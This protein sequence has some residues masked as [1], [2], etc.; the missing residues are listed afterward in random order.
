[1]DPAS[2]ASLLSRAISL[3]TGCYT[4]CSFLKK[5]ISDAKKVDDHLRLCQ[6]EGEYLCVVLDQLKAI[7]KTQQTLIAKT[8]CVEEKYLQFMKLSM[9]DFLKLLKDWQNKLSS[10][11]RPKTTA[12]RRAKMQAEMILKSDDFEELQGQIGLNKQNI[13]LFLQVLNVYVFP[14][15]GGSGANRVK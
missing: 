11:E 3:A 6:K 9:E 1:M 7:L 8:G 13:S 14:R 10:V 5:F 4:F 12:F 15:L 2:I